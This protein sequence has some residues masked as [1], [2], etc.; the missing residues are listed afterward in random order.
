LPAAQRS[1]SGGDDGTDDDY[2][3]DNADLEEAFAIFKEAI[4]DDEESDGDEE[5]SDEDDM[6]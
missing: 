2:A 3:G 5:D 6:K 4:E 1:A